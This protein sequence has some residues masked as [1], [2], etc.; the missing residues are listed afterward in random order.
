MD[1][2]AFVHVMNEASGMLEAGD[3]AGALARLTAFDDALGEQPDPQDYGWIVSYRFR[4][5]FGAGDYAQALHIAENGPARFA[6]DI[7][8]GSMAT[9][10]SMAVE[11]ATQLGRAESAVAMADKCI[12]LRRQV[13]T[14]DEVLMGAMTACTLLGDLER[15]DLATRY[16]L[17]LIAEGEGAEKYRAY[18]YYALCAA[19]EHKVGDGVFATL[20]SGRDWLGSV[21]NE[22]AREA[23]AY[24]DNSLTVRDLLA[25]Q[26]PAAGAQFPP[27]A[28]AAGG[29][30]LPPPTSPAAGG[31]PL[32]PPGGPATGG[33]PLPPPMGQGDSG[34][35]LLPPN[36]GGS[37]PIS[38][39]PPG[40]AS[41]PI[42]LPPPDGV[43]AVPLPPPP[44]QPNPF[45]GPVP[46]LEPADPPAPQPFPMD[47]PTQY[48][49]VSGTFT[50]PADLESQPAPREA[51]LDALH[52]AGHGTNLVHGQP[53]A[54]QCAGGETADALLAAGRPGVA[55]AAY[56]ALIDEAIDSGHPDLLIMGKAVLGLMMALI[57]D[58]R[59]GEAHAVWIDESGATAIG[60]QALEHGQTSVHD[61][62]G[63]RLL[64]A[65]FHALAV[66][67]RDSALHAVNTIMNSCVDYAFER[68][69]EVVPG[70]IN[71]WRRHLYE[72]FDDNPP[73]DIFG[74]V[75]AAEARWGQPVPLGPLYWSRPSPWVV[76]WL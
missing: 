18:G 38:L 71:N 21:D 6:A 20:W 29:L 54:D 73:P 26:Q 23:R 31:V 28:G 42:P 30:P 39:P 24:L 2:N 7:P 74:P 76:D 19:L 49:P 35:P 27:P 15:F 75:E 53:P 57:F 14:H 3:A 45:G 70:M 60:I 48:L 62:H 51:L 11:A 32:P 63:Y 4:S 56:R 44:A 58:N 65:Y 9:M 64:E 43:A 33:V 46:G 12:A 25:Q 22:F 66:T 8:S 36:P 16:A 61:L 68:E 10:Y 67:D 5:A 13:G 1:R 41:V 69:R 37:A 40:P 17:L 55:A 50:V 72:L 52:G 47:A 59:V 34:I